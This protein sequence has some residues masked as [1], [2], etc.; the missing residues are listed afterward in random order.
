MSYHLPPGLAFLALPKGVHL[1]P[2][3]PSGGGCGLVGKSCAT[4]RT[5]GP[6]ALARQAPL[7][8]GF[9]RQEYWNRLPFPSSGALPDKGI[10]PGSLALQ[11]DSVPTEPPG[12]P[13]PI[14]DSKQEQVPGKPQSN[15][16]SKQGQVLTNWKVAAEPAQSR[17]GDIC[18]PQSPFT[19]D[20]RHLRGRGAGGPEVCSKSFS[21]GTPLVWSLG[22][23]FRVFTS[24]SSEPNIQNSTC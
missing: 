13:Q 24:H 12:N 14:L 6:V 11:A 17:A 21:S 4:L 22:P 20:D 2:F 3:S 23:H 8:M 5:P 10:E 18:F 19:P 9:P 7:S 16:A 15:L 1:N